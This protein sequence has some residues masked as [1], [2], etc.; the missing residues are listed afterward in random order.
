MFSKHKLVNV[1]IVT[2]ANARVQ[3]NTTG[4]KISRIQDV[5]L[6]GRIQDVTLLGQG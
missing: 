5:T 4:S 2:L 3:V 6:L 1:G